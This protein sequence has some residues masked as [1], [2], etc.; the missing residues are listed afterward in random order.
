M[1]PPTTAAPE[2]QKIMVENKI[3]H[4]PVVGAGKR[5]VGLVTRERLRIPP[6]DL[7]SLNV[8]EISRFLSN[9]SVKELMV[10]DGDLVTIEPDAVLEEAAQIMAKH[11]IGCLPV[12]E[13]GIVVGVITETDMLIRLSELMGGFAPGVRATIRVPN[14]IG[15]A[16]QV[17]S[18]IAAK[19]WGIYGSGG[20]PAPKLPGYWDMMLKVQGGSLEEV[21]A[22][23]K[24]LEDLEILDVRE[25]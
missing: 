12:L 25:T 18:A 19:G 22:A 14:V 13:E 15:E 7:S 4:L 2:A 6:T 16:A 17:T 1:I 5:L 21:V 24:E 3:R 8:W 10:K 23:L 9:L 11:R 20:L